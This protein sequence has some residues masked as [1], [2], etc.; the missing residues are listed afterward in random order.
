MTCKR[1]TGKRGLSGRFPGGIGNCRADATWGNK[2][3]TRPPSAPERFPVSGLNDAT[4]FG[5]PPEGTI[6]ELE[7]IILARFFQMIPPQSCL[8]GISRISIRLR[9]MLA[10]CPES[11]CS[12]TL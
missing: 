12:F 1:A 2:L 5:A 6:P 11:A 9:L 4:Y 10:L 3:G 7:T 8:R